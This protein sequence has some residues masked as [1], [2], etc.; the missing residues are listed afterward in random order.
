MNKS[1]AKQTL[2][3]MPARG[4]FTDSSQENNAGEVSTH[5]NNRTKS[6][7]TKN[8]PNDRGKESQVHFLMRDTDNVCS[9]SAL[10]NPGGSTCLSSFN[11]AKHQN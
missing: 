10:N 8:A 5:C 1:K 11:G 6:D 9:W 4:T 3:Q 7:E 2:E